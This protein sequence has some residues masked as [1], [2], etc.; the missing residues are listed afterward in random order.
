MAQGRC[1]CRGRGCLPTWRGTGHQ[2][3]LVRGVYAPFGVGEHEEF[4][5]VK[6][7]TSTWGRNAAPWGGVGV[8]A[9]CEDRP[10]RGPPGGGT[11][12]GL[13]RPQGRWGKARAPG[14][15]TQSF[16]PF[17][18]AH[19]CCFLSQFLSVTSLKIESAFSWGLATQILG[20]RNSAGSHL[21]GCCYRSQEPRFLSR[22]SL[23]RLQ[24]ALPL[25][26]NHFQGPRQSSESQAW[27]HA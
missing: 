4:G 15:R 26:F 10:M 17:A 19:C 5:Q 2:K 22:G 25:T 23:L 7:R 13:R 6:A 9:S 24:I 11:L 14:P 3:P 8:G 21:P 1:S 12:N 18:V 20:F 16:I 27:R